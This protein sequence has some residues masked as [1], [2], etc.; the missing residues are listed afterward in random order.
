MEGLHCYNPASNCEETNLTKP[1]W[2]YAHN[3]SGG[4]SVTGGYVYS[5][6]NAVE[7]TGKYIYGDYVSGN[8]W[9]LE[10]N[11]GTTNN[12]LISSTNY[13]VS[14]FGVDENNELYFADYNGQIYKFKGTTTGSVGNTIKNDFKLY[15]NYPNPFN[16]STI[17]SFLLPVGGQ[18]AVHLQ[19]YDILGNEITTLI[20]GIKLSGFQNI[21]FNSGSLA[22]GVY[23]YTLSAG[24]YRETKKMTLL[25]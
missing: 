22:S 13:N 8:I 23:Y 16:P 4:F 25:R 18:H 9:K 12:S 19:I 17:I 15:Q 6:N 10:Y 2:E 5:G 24:I 7:L 1:I 3:S 14:T 11:N 20:N 21:N